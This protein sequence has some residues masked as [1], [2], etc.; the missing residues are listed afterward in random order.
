METQTSLQRLAALD[1]LGPYLEPT[2]LL[3]RLEALE[4]L[5]GRTPAAFATFLDRLAY[6]EAQKAAQ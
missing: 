1:G 5:Y 4:S 6:V 2:T 3:G